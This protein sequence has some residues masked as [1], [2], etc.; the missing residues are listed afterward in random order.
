MIPYQPPP[1]LFTGHLQTIYPALCRRLPEPAY[2][3]ERIATPDGDFLD[4]DWLPNSN[5]RLA[6]IAHGLEGHSRR[7]YV[8]GMAHAL[9]AA[10][11]DVLAWNFRG[12]GGEINRRPRFTHNGA[13]EDLE[14]VVHH[15]L[16]N[17]RYRRLALVGFSMGGNL[18]LVYLGRESNRVPAEMCG[19]VVYSV[20]CDL[21]AA[22]ARLADWRNRLYM[23]RFVGQMG[24][25]IRLLAR[26]FPQQLS[27]DGYHR[28]RTFADFDGRYTAPLHGFSSAED[29]WAQCSSAVYLAEIAVP[30]WIVNARNDPFLAPT[31][32]PIQQVERNPNL[33]LLSPDQGGHCGFVTSLFPGPSWAD[34]MA[35]ELLDSC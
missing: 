34:L 22:A 27:A 30:T 1:L 4:L 5:N 21:A 8:V 32:F 2:Q 24:T 13:T 28:I 11:W 16:A 23:A 26:R 35:C 29:Y 33:N 20:P 17:G 9:A 14:A 10:G 12:C 6:I 7:A 18:T 3:R 25:K 19:A 31:C 15:A